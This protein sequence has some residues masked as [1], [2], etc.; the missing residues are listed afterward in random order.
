MIVRNGPL[1]AWDN[2][3]QRYTGLIGDVQYGYNGG[4]WNGKGIVTSQSSAQ[5]P[6]TLTAIATATAGEVGYGGGTFGGV[7]VSAADVLLFYTWGGDANLDGTL[8]GDDYF[9][10]DNNVN[11][12]GSVF[13]Y[14]NGDFNYDGAINGD[15]YFIID[16]N[17][18]V[19]QNSTPFPTSGSAPL[20]AVPEPGPLMM[21]A[22]AGIP[23][24]RRRRWRR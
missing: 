9:Q 23:A 3:L 6:N 18:N 17:I 2:T 13:G 12:S 7:S 22:L 5:S 15:D 4:D 11:Q 19:G 8:N 1:G 24:L 21:M 16:N 14:N 20:S 10:I